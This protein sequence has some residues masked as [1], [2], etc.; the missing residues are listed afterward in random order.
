MVRP[1]KPGEDRLAGRRYAALVALFFSV[2]SFALM[3]G[4]ASTNHAQGDP[5]VGEQKGTQPVNPPTVPAKTSSVIPPPPMTP[6]GS[7]A[8]LA[9]LS[10]GR[11]LAI[12]EATWQRNTQS[13]P[14]N[15]GPG[16]GPQVQA[17][18]REGQ[19]PIQPTGWAPSGPSTDSP[20]AMLQSRGVLNPQ[21]ENVPEGVRVSGFVRDRV[22]PTRLQ[23]V[24][25]TARDYA[26]A[27]QALVQQI[28][29][30]R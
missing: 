25:A 19:T 23:F 28:D 20:D 29:Q 13:P 26:T 8:A 15:I 9:S 21:Q 1:R 11:P 14:G 30:L 16:A 12:Q 24:E 3:N 17:V 22:T 2:A 4:C 27:V 6:S 18:P 10:G 7:N 5:L